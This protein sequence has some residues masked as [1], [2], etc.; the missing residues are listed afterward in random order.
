MFKKIYRDRECQ[1]ILAARKPPIFWPFL[2][3]AMLAWL[4]ACK[5]TPMAVNLD[6][7]GWKILQGQAIWRAKEDAP[8]IAG[9]LVMA[10]N[11]DG[12]TFVE[13]TK[14][15]LPLMVGQTATNSWQI[16]FVPQNRSLSGRGKPPARLGWLYVAGCTEGLPPP[17]NWRLQQTHY[18]RWRMEHPDRGEV[19]DWLLDLPLPASHDVLKGETLASI[20]EWYGITE[21]ALRSANPI[22]GGVA[23]KVND[24]LTLPSS[25]PSQ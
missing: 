15:P 9:E 12:R 10:T 25:G 24:T 18:N 5:T 21:P 20:A 14:D 11:A 2:I 8:E 19:L 1:R 16:E 3:F 23:P 6:E 7:T 4:T 17:E 22:L 13:F